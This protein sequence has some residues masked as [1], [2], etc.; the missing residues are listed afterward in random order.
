[1]LRKKLLELLKLL[2]LLELPAKGSG[3][4]NPKDKSTMHRS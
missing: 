2:K 1:M 4:S 3:K